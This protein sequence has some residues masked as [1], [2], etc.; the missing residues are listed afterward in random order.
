MAGLNADSFERAL[1]KFKQNLSPSLVRKFSICKLEDV[2][3]TIR[4]IQDQQGK[5]GR[6]RNMRRL[7]EF[8]EAM[9]Q[10]GGVIDVFVNANQFVCFVWNL[11]PLQI[12]K[13]HLDS[14]DKLLDVYGQI[15]A[16]IPGLLQHRATFENHPTLA[17]V[18]ED[19]YSDILRFHQEALSVF[20]R[21]KWKMMFHATWKTFE[22]K[23]NPILQSLTMRRELLEAEKSSATLYEVRKVRED[24]ETMCQEQRRLA[25]ATEKEKHKL[26]VSEVRSKLQAVDYYFDQQIHT[27]DR[28][29]K[30]SG[31]WI[32][33]EP[34]FRSWFDA[35]SPGHGVLY[36]NGIPGAGKTTLMSH[37]IEELLQQA[38][39]SHRQ[40][41]STYFFFK[42]DQP[43]KNTHNSLLR[44][45]LDQLINH[46]SAVSDLFIEEA[47]KLADVNFRSTASLETLV[48]RGFEC[49]HTSYLILDGLDECSKGET[50]KSVQWLLSLTKGGLD[51]S[52]N[53]L[54][55]IFAGQRDGILDRLLDSQPSIS[56]EYLDAHAEDIRQYCLEFCE[57]IQEKFKDSSLKQ[58]IIELVTEG[59]K[60][61]FLYAHVVLE[62]LL[63]QTRLTQLRRELQPGIFPEEIERAYERVVVRVLE[64][65]SKAERNDAQKVLGLVIGAKRILAWREI[66]AFYC[67]EPAT[68]AVSLDE[69]LLV[70]CKQL[71]G[72]LLDVHQVDG[73]PGSPDN[74]VQIVHETARHFLIMRKVINVSL[75]NARLS[76]FCTQYLTS[77]P[78]QPGIGGRQIRSH[79]GNGSYSLQDYAV[80]FWFQ[81]LLE[82]VGSQSQWESTL[83]PTPVDSARTF[84]MSYGI[85]DA[86]LTSLE[87]PSHTETV[88]AIQRLPSD[89][90]ERNSCLNIELRTTVIRREIEELQ[91]DPESTEDRNLPRGLCGTRITYKCSK[92][93]CEY[94]RSGFNTSEEQKRHI[95]RHELPFYC[96]EDCFA[97]G[98]GFD[99]ASKLESHRRNYHSEKTDQIRFP[100]LK[101]RIKSSLC[102]AA[103]QG[104]LAT[105]IELLDAGADIDQTSRNHGGCSPLQLA[106]SEGHF[107]IIRVL[108]S[109]GAHINFQGQHKYDSQTALHRAA[110]SGHLEI[111]NLL[112]SQD[113]IFPDLKDVNDK[114]PFL[115][116]I[117]EN[118]LDVV[119][120]M[121]DCKIVN[122]DLKS[123]QG[124]PLWWAC[125]NGNTNLVQYL[126]QKGFDKVDDVSTLLEL[127]IN[128][129]EKDSTQEILEI[130]LSAG[131]LEITDQSRVSAALE[132]RSIPLTRKVLSH[133]KLDIGL[134]VLK[135][136]SRRVRK[137]GSQEMDILIRKRLR[138]R[139]DVSIPTLDTRTMIKHCDFLGIDEVCRTD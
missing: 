11:R 95:S 31:K 15:G 2:K 64:Q 59:A 40:T 26:R 81:H 120:L 42:H 1:R 53:R 56:L 134:S 45:T 18:L 116:A 79:A 73:N 19:Y 70:S 48:K 87:N 94:F 54:R 9:N 34:R 7:D 72:S 65:A 106:A 6:L 91:R 13:T 35:D 33:E 107:E 126:L 86:F 93:W 60:G 104:D 57:R 113:T 110:G 89:S 129:H 103:R 5:A 61:M 30:A 96:S 75:E 133:P 122:V 25:S 68:G 23:F 22:T 136:V 16:A 39:I 101:S 76:L 131:N 88:K 121:L 21:P 74:V 123:A 92:P 36:V 128:N 82:C 125:W 4:D 97:S 117:S 20:E 119:Q 139:A 112:L 114:T 41:C 83:G 32:F 85:S 98:L 99:S 108:I 58:T 62:N 102:S 37:V 38:S 105:V 12:A 55:I 78:F 44:A 50:E 100:K 8:I 109:R 52:T 84:L 124:G 66:Q 135:A 29:S 10:F 111:V 63:H 138:Q 51:A 43:E 130:L 127:L 14:F 69:R 71:C 67:I 28:Y 17:T 49:Y 24:I 27:E 118:R 90:R 47:A 3:Q 77:E 115:C 80:Q 132:C 137:L 46:D